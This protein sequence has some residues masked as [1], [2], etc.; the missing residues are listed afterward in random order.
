MTAHQ[1]PPPVRTSA[2]RMAWRLVLV[3][4][5]SFAVHLLL[6]WVRDHATATQNSRLMVGALVAT[7]LAYVVLTAIPFVPGAEIGI[8]LIIMQ[9]AAIAPF[10][11]LATVCALML[12]YLVGRYVPERALHRFFLDL[13]FHAACRL[14]ETIQPLGPRR[15]LALLRRRVP[16]WLAPVVTDYRYVLLALLV[17]LPGNTLIGGGGGIALVAGF[18]RLFGPWAT[19]ATF[20]L[21]VLPVPALV[22]IFGEHLPI[23]F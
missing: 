22:L 8:S 19:L 7:F 11:Y 17:N 12:A 9:G 21:A 5:V 18:S 20:M 3:L 13:R 15:R 6:D 14:I 2:L 23:G 4:A 16:G 1:A 10:V